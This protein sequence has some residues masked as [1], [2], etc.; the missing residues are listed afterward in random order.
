MNIKKLVVGTLEENCYILTKDNKT[1]I[2][3]PGDEFLKID[4]EI[5]GEL[6]GI[7]IT[8]HHFDHIGALDELKNKYNVPV[9]DFN[10][11]K[12]LEPFNYTIIENPGHTKDSIS[13]YFKEEQI[14]F[15]G[16]FIFKGTIGRTDFPTGN[17]NDMKN[18]L[19]YL[20]TLNEN[21]TLYPGH[22]ES[23]TIKEEKENL[24]YIINYY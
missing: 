6:I 11:K 8:H 15:C 4:K 24:E 13:I 10:N 14:I 17:M 23:T 7:I 12:K 16:D 9:I 1:I 2:I 5:E 19:K 20:I 21:I 3:D 22:Y 18:S